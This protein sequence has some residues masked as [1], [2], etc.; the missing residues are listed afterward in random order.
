M[1]MCK[2]LGRSVPASILFVK[3]LLFEP[4]K[5]NKNKIFDKNIII[6]RMKS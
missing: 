4:P 5:I 3:R 2:A 6:D 1:S